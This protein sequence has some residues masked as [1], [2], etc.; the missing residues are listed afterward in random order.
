MPRCNL[1]AAGGQG[2]KE[3]ALSRRA[4]QRQLAADVEQDIGLAR[5]DG[6][7]VSGSDRLVVEV[8]PLLLVDRVG[9]VVAGAR[10]VAKIWSFHL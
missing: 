10:S 5:S 7:G 4:G 2:S 1:A 9:C 8:E 6:L 3:R